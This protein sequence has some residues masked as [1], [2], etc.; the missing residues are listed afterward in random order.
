MDGKVERPEASDK[1][2]EL[3]KMAEKKAAKDKKDM[4]HDEILLTKNPEEYTFQPNA[5]KYKNVKSSRNAGNSPAVQ[6]SQR[7]H[8]TQTRTQRRQARE[9]SEPPA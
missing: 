8:E 6:R 4:N 1:W 9:R 7:L 2:M 3:Y 5:H